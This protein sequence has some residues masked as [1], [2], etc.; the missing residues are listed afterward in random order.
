M[1][2]P[3]IP[4]GAAG[5][6]AAA[7]FAAKRAAKKAVAKGIKRKA[8]AQ[9]AAKKAIERKREKIHP[10]DYDWEMKR[11]VNIMKEHGIKSKYT[12]QKGKKP[13]L[14]VQDVIYNSKTGKTTKKYKSLGSSPSIK[15][16]KN[17]L[18][19]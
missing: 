5:L 17:W 1:P 9:K 3:I 18:G 19:Y 7:R 4:I 11:N 6:S 12:Q 8:T 13:V 2:L 15:R 14:Q 16:M 10:T